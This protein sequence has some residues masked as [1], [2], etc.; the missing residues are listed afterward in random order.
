[1]SNNTT[2]TL[3]NE[4][5]SYFSRKLLDYAIQELHLNEFAQQ[6]ELPKN[7]GS[8]KI[9]FFR[10]GAGDSSNV[11]TLAE[12]ITPTTTR[13]LTISKIEV[14][15]AQL[16]EVAVV[17]DLLSMT[18][19]FD[20]LTQ[21][22]KTM[23]EDAALKADDVSRNEL[24]SAG[25]VRYAQQTANFAGLG[26]ASVG[27]GK[28]LSTDALDIATRL[29]INRGKPFGGAYVAVVPPHVSRDLQN[30]DNWIWADRYAGSTK[31]FKGELGMLNGVRYVEATNPFIENATEGTYDATGSIYSSM[32][33]AQNAFGVPKLAGDSPAKPRVLITPM[34]ASDSDPL[35]QRRKAGWKA[36]YA[37]KMLNSAWMR[38]YKSKSAFD[39]NLNA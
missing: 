12:G 20:A 39:A 13:D 38:V 30:D 31:I 28:F 15:L 23:G 25:T 9:A 33:L 18:E 7:V 26:G 32:F 3:T 17:T 35:A 24:I 10:Y 6:S 1:M 19:L 21:G 34:A 16:G 11:Q 5:Q 36:F 29:K 8:L 14:T 2:T 27:S 37:A 22:I 4:Y